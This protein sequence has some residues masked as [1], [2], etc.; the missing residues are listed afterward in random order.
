MEGRHVGV[1]S[2][3]LGSLQPGD[4]IRV[5]VRPCHDAFRPP[6]IVDKSPIIMIS[7][8]T[9]IA[10]F[11]GFIQER[12]AQ[13]SNSIKLSVAFLFHGCREADHDDLY[14]K[15]LTSWQ[16]QG[17]VKVYRTY[18]RTPEKSNGNKYV[19]DALWAERAQIVGLWIRGAKIYICGSQKMGQ[20]VAE[21]LQRMLANA[22]LLQGD[23][24]QWWNSL[25]NIR[26]AIDV[27][28]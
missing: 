10:P 13:L 6:A 4:C 16:D 1:A 17:A 22:S 28:D 8:G 12:A 5:A 2:S 25:R 20:A 3:Y 27:F 18:S 26:Y 24:K 11:R 19:Q 14:A 9:G 15:D 7:A 21:T 23:A